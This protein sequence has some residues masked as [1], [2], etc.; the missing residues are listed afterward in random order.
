MVLIFA[1][2]FFFLHPKIYR[3]SKNSPT[4]HLNPTDRFSAADNMASAV[5]GQNA[6]VRHFVFLVHGWKGTHR[7][8]LYL[9]TALVREAR[10]R[11]C[12]NK[13]IIRT[14]KCNDDMTQDGVA[15]GGRRLAEEII[16]AVQGSGTSTVSLVGNSLG[17]LYCRYAV[18]ELHRRMNDEDLGLGDLYFN[19]F[20]SISSPHLGS[21]RH[22]YISLPK[23]VES[24]I[25]K[26][27][28]GGQTGIDLFRLN[29]NDD[30]NQERM[31]GAAKVLDSNDI[32]YAMGTESN[33]L[34]PLGKFRER[35]A[36]AGAYM[37]DL[38]VSTETAAFLHKNSYVEHVVRRRERDGALDGKNF[39]I[40]E[41]KT[42]MRPFGTNVPRIAE[43][44]KVGSEEQVRSKIH[45]M[46][47]SL[48][49][50]GWRKVFVDTRSVLPA[51]IRLLPRWLRRDSGALSLK[52]GQSLTSCDLIP[53]VTGI[54]GGRINI[55]PLG[56]TTMIANSKN[57]AVTWLNKA[58]QPVVDCMAKEL[59]E[60]ILLWDFDSPPAGK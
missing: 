56:H 52:N 37:T 46:S 12:D 2:F 18:A 14:A 10:A 9:E 23:S 11:R 24:A 26:Y 19:L 3:A 28:V 5:S 48:D 29:A 31:P 7:E 20:A 50:L 35:V 25:G 34:I 43:E 55:I 38:M 32:V 44:R 22:S 13:V 33:F 40:A 21:Y 47:Y 45:R 60:D 6:A 58:G 15:A 16:A 8:M 1:V 41:V 57:A 51:T 49:S 59:I 4:L 30:S 54:E 17:G 27:A 39:F 42:A 36:Y 53:L